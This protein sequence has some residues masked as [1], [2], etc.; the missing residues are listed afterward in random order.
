[1]CDKLPVVEKD[2]LID[3]SDRALEQGNKFIVEVSDEVTFENPELAQFLLN[4][5][6]NSKQPDIAS[7]AVMIFLVI[8]KSF[9]E[10]IKQ[11]QQL[12]S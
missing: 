8:Y 4:Y 10:Q 11:N 3:V 5:V 9:K 7:S 12:A 2:V 6:N 1:M